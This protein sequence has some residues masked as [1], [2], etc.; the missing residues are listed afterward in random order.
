MRDHNDGVALVRKLRK[1]SHDFN[2]GFRI[3][4]PSRLIRQED[5]RFVDQCARNRHALALAARKLVRLVV[6][7]VT[8]P[9]AVQRVQ[10]NFAPLFRADPRIDQRQLDIVQGIGARQQIER[11]KNEADLP[12]SNLGQ[13]I[14][15]HLAHVRA[16]ELVTSGAGRI[17]AADQVHQRGFA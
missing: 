4:V 7:A 13:L 9:D 16:V 12:I 8:K 5:R 3:Q 1:Q 2:P 10:S 17:Q 11:L 15:V 6:D 14:I